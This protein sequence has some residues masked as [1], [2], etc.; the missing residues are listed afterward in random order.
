MTTAEQVENILK[1]SH[2]ARNSDTELL[3]VYMQ[4][5]G[6]NLT[7]AQ[8]QKLKEMPS[9]E[10]ITRIRRKLQEQ[11]KYPADQDVNEARYE[12]FKEYQDPEKIL[13]RK[14]YYVRPFG[15]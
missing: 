8:I 4:K 12:K 2:K 9:S 13:E 1:F 5:Y 14:G 15:E 10:T 6:L 7:D 3:I 11:G